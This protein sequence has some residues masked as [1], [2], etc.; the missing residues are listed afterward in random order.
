MSDTRLE[1]L[2]LSVA[3]GG[4]TVLHDVSL[5]VPRGQITALL[6][7]N[8]AGKSTLVMTVAG[9]LPRSSGQMTVD[10]HDVGGMRPDRVRASGI[11]V[12][13][14]HRVVADLTV[15]DNLLLAGSTLPKAEVR[16]ALD[17]ALALLPELMGHLEAPARSLSGGQKQMVAFC[18]ALIARPSY[19]LIDELSLG[20]APLVVQRLMTAVKQVVAAGTGV[21]LIEQF[22]ALALDAA[23][24]ACV[25]EQG[26][27]A[28]SGPAE[29][30]RRQPEILHS[31]Y[32][33]V[34]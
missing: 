20:L 7:P 8:G 23:T 3:R 28:W 34:H 13:E 4:R 21:L 33:A 19:L 16:S 12:P 22:V 27:I 17:D 18:Q 24:T 32:L 31:S 6:G 26:R 30:L 2:G 1:I 5:C 14:G 29:E 15:R 10:G 25:L 9:E 11:V